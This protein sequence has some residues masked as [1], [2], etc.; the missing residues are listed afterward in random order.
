MIYPIDRVTPAR[1]SCQ[2][3]VPS[4]WGGVFCVIR[5]LSRRKWAIKET[6]PHRGDSLSGRP[7]PG[8]RGTVV[9]S[10]GDISVTLDLGKVHVDLLRMK[11]SDETY[12]RVLTAV[13]DGIRVASREIEEA[14]TKDPEWR[15]AIVD[16]ECDVIENLLG[17]AFVVCQNQIS[18]VVSGAWK[19]R[20]FA[21]KNNRP[22]TAFARPEDIRAMAKPLSSSCAY[23]KVEAIWAFGN[24]FKHREEWDHFDWA[25]LTGQ[26]VKTVPVIQA[27]GAESGSTGNLRTGMEAIIGNSK[28]ENLQALSEILRKW[29]EK[30]LQVTGKEMG[31]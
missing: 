26:A 9:K 2:G 14:K 3:Y 30:A 6:G 23:S 13:S 15:D 7:G 27:A 16:D 25:K 8:E 4:L 17:S 20:D 22:F 11:V 28:Y 12:I 24:Y 1:L 5:S 18:A 19:A 31:C 10:Q 21:I 29:A